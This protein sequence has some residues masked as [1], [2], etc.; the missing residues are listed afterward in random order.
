MSLSKKLK[1]I[2]KSSPATA[3]L[4]QYLESSD[5]RIAAVES[6]LSN[7]VDNDTIYDDTDLWTAIGISKDTDFTDENFVDLNTDV[8]ACK[9]AIESFSGG[10]AQYCTVKI[11]G[12]MIVDNMGNYLDSIDEYC[13]SANVDQSI[14]E[15]LE[16]GGVLNETTY[17]SSFA[18]YSTT[19]HYLSPMQMK[20]I[21]E[22]N[23]VF[24]VFTYPPLET[25]VEY[26]VA[27]SITWDPLGSFTSEE[28]V[29]EYTITAPESGGEGDPK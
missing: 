12:E 19:E 24:Y 15:L 17:S 6:V 5:S 26:T 2:L 18:L 11:P 16:A 21:E 28:G 9:E 4:I 3:S 20:A 27:S 13:E 7:A 22:D 14:K 10:G 25:G 23:E 1:N 29:F 8:A